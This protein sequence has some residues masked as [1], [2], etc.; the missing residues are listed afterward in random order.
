MGSVGCVS[1]GYVSVVCVR[2]D[3]VSTCVGVRVYGSVC[4]DVFVFVCAGVFVHMCVRRRTFVCIRVVVGGVCVGVC[5]CHFGIR[6]R[7]GIALVCPCVIS[8][9]YVCIYKGWWCV[10]VYVYIC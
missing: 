1:Q 5:T 9:L 7:V 8:V 3:G 2:M 6:V 10:G 4:T